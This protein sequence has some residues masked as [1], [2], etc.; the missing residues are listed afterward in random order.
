MAVTR[1]RTGN[2]AGG[3]RGAIGRN[4]RQGRAREGPRVRRLAPNSTDPDPRHKNAHANANQR[5]KGLR[6]EAQG[7][8]NA[9]ADPTLGFQLDLFSAI[10]SASILLCLEI[11]VVL[12]L[13][14][15]EE[16]GESFETALARVCRC[17]SGGAATDD[18][19]DSDIEVV[20]DYLTTT[21][22]PTA[23]H[24]D[25]SNF[26]SDIS[27]QQGNVGEVKSCE[28][29]EE[30]SGLDFGG[31]DQ[32]VRKGKSEKSVAVFVTPL[33]AL[34]IIVRNN[35][36]YNAVLAHFILNER[37]QRMG[38]LGC[39]LCIVCLTVIVL[40]F[41]QEKTPNSVEQIWDLAAQS[42]ML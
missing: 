4:P 11:V 14:P 17:I 40:H 3:E 38:V 39:M 7:R 41:P 5:C 6:Q 37:L 27:W 20:D 21:S 36:G 32:D 22:C 19:D 23:Y 2:S 15:K 10:R 8:H 9:V 30:G 16:D 13:V 31:N 35:D 25:G 33:G 26:S 12:S 1:G 18:A 29:T 42:G 24:G 28:G 34:S